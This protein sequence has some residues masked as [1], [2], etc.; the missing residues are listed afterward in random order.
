MEEIKKIP[1]FANENKTTQ[2][3]NGR[4]RRQNKSAGQRQKIMKTKNMTNNEVKKGARQEVKNANESPRYNLRQA[5]KLAKG[6]DVKDCEGVSVEVLREQYRR[7]CEV[8]G[9][10]GYWWDSVMTD[11]RG[12]LITSLRPLRSLEDLYLPTIEY[13]GQ[14]FVYR[15]AKWSVANIVT[16]AA[17]RL[18]QAEGLAKAFNA[19]YSWQSVS[20]KKGSTKKAQKGAIP[21]KTAKALKDI[22]QRLRDGKLTKAAAADAIAALLAA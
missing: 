8:F 20:T 1:T 14:T 5:N 6:A 19:P 12:G 18:S 7:I 16:S 4:A 2:F 13:C 22:N 10:D 9:A 17:I 15:T 3:F 21:A 11:G